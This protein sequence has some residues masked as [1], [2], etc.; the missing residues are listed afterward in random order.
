MSGSA[1]T[2]TSGT[3]VDENVTFYNDNLAYKIVES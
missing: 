2:V 3:A 1:P